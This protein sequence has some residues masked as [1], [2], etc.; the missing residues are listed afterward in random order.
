MYFFCAV[1]WINLVFSEK[2]VMRV[3]SLYRVDGLRTYAP[4][5]NRMTIRKFERL[6]C[7]SGFRVA[8]RKDHCSKNMNFFAA[9]PILRELFINQVDAVLTK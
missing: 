2:T 6:I 8:S 1:P 5:L 7:H 9:I 3:R 4:E